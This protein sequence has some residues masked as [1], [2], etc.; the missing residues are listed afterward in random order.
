[1]IANLSKLH[2]D[3]VET[4]CTRRR[5]IAIAGYALT[6]LL[7]QSLLPRRELATY[8]L[9]YL[10]RKLIQNLRLNATKHKRTQ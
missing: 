9:F 1:M 5:A 8:N 4:T 3:V 10:L 2:H 7:V 6:N